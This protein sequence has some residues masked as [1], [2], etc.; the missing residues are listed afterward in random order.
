M[1]MDPRIAAAA[2]GDAAAMNAL[3]TSY[4][5]LMQKA[6][7][8]R[9]LWP[10]RED[11]L[12]EARL[13]FLGAIHSYDAALGIPFAGYAKAKVYG[14]LRTF[15]K[16]SRRQWQREVFPTPASGAEGVSFWDTLAAPSPAASLDD[17]YAVAD[18]ILHLPDRQQELLHL[19]YEKEYTQ[20]AAAAELGITQQAAAAMKNRAIKKLKDLLIR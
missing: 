19:L 11:A 1:K 10:I 12:A 16:R 20:K 4:E 17:I 8:Q 18:A 15:F 13:S 7:R 6:A 5:G 14:D 2:Q 9:H 3:F